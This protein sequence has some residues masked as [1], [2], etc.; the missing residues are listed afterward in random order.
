MEQHDTTFP[1]W[2]KITLLGSGLLIAGFIGLIIAAVYSAP[3]ND[4]LLKYEGEEKEIG[5]AALDHSKKSGTALFAAAP[6]I[7]NIMIVP[8]EGSCDVEIQAGE[9]DALTGTARFE[10]AT[11]KLGAFNLSSETSKVYVCRV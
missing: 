1:I 7:E 5:Q 4:G 6:T 2:A 3:V 10:V 11:K 9:D 8:S